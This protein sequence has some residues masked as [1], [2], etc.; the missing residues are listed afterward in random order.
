MEENAHCPFPEKLSSP[1]ILPL[2]EFFVCAPR[3]G[4]VPLGFRGAEPSRAQRTGALGMD[5]GLVSVGTV[6]RSRGA[7]TDKR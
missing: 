7:A 3:S 4:A 5:R 2:N 1:R 6:R